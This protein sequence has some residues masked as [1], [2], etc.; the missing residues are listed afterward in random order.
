MP[1]D[2]FD[3]DVIYSKEA[4]ALDV[5]QPLGKSMAGV[6]KYCLYLIHVLS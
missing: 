6:Q 2:P 1:E 3:L 5:H 4:L